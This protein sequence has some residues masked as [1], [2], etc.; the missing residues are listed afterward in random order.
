[1]SGAVGGAAQRGLRAP[2]HPAWPLLSAP[3]SECGLFLCTAA[4]L[5]SGMQG[6][7]W[8]AHPQVPLRGQ[9]WQ[10]GGQSQIQPWSAEAWP[11]WETPAVGVTAS[12]FH[13]CGEMHTDGEIEAQGS[14]HL[15]KACGWRTEERGFKPMSCGSAGKESACNAGD[16][17]SV[18]GSGRSPGEEIG[19]PLPY[20]GLEN[21]M[22]CIVPGVTKSRTGL[23][24]FHFFTGWT[25]ASQVA[26][27]VK[28]PPANAGGPDP[29]SGRSPGEG[30]DFPLQDP[31]LENPMD[32]GA[33]RATVLG[34]AE[35]RTGLRD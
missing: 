12:L 5:G 15:L 32:R 4:A 23:S 11:F 2:P 18:P 20:S 6:P 25:G 19:C 24:D 13:P 30:N 10:A 28:N 27:L 33:W 14:G 31:G 16:L 26:M 8:G 29:W 22:H 3:P 21:P 17:G 35:N 9:T 34:V 7:C 1:M